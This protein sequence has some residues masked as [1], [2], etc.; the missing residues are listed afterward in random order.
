[1]EKVK[2]QV[3]I[4][5]L[6]VPLRITLLIPS[7]AAPVSQKGRKCFPGQTAWQGRGSVCGWEWTLRDLLGLLKQGQRLGVTGKVTLAIVWS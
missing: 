5:P 3:N 4:L 1:M 2:F 6:G 7:S